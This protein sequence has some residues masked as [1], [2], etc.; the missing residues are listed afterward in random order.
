V[1]P[2]KLWIITADTDYFTKF[3]NEWLLNQLLN[4]DLVS[5]CGTQPEIRCYDDLSD[6]LTDFANEIGIRPNRISTPEETKQIKKEI[7]FWN[8]QTY[9]QT[10]R[11]DAQQTAA[12]VQAL[13]SSIP[14]ST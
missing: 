11:L 13:F 6:G 7:G 9:S 4:R 10:I 14:R 2:E 8:T 12:F 1:R 3:E 5:A